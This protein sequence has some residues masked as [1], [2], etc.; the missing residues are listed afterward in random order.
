MTKYDEG[1]KATEL[2]SRNIEVLAS[3]EISIPKKHGNVAPIAVT[4]LLLSLHLN[5]VFFISISS[6]TN[7]SLWHLSVILAIAYYFM[8]PQRLIVIRRSFNTFVPAVFLL[9]WLFAQA[10]RS[11]DL[12]R[13]ITMILSLGLGLVVFWIMGNVLRMRRDLARLNYTVFILGLLISG[14]SL[15]LYLRVLVRHKEVA[16][17]EELWNVRTNTV[18]EGDR[19]NLLRL[20]GFSGDP[21]FFALYLLPSL[22]CGL[23]TNI[24]IRWKL[25]GVS[26]ILLAIFFSYSRG[27]A[28]SMTLS[29]FILIIHS[30]RNPLY[31]RYIMMLSSLFAIFV[32]VAFVSL[33]TKRFSVGHWWTRFTVGT[34]DNR[35]SM[36]HILAIQFDSFYSLLIGFGLRSGENM[37]GVVSHN[38]YLD[39]L[40]DTG[41]V[42][43][44]LF[45]IFIFYVLSGR[46]I[47]DDVVPY[48]LPWI[49]TF[50]VLLLALPFYSILHHPLLWSTAAIVISSKEI[51][52]G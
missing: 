51:E 19:G 18:Y 26:V 40:F 30:V 5:G 41:L 12:F 7:I 43:F 14:L 42:G 47:T 48:S 27:I 9:S 16:L 25:P 45:V 50:L 44:L 38:T 33:M 1:I 24:R 35:F 11:P 8:Q 20:R 2:R 39:L 23:V 49:H 22:F 21:N 13:S 34:S 32:F 15:I 52:E 6:H 37:L 4:L 28:L 3:R 31:R 17:I 29:I 36:W 46:H 10:F